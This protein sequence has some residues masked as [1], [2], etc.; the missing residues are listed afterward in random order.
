MNVDLKMNSLA[1][2]LGIEV[3]ESTKICR[4]CGR[5]LPVTAFRWRGEGTVRKRINIDC[6]EC[7]AADDR[8]RS[9]LRKTAPP[10]PL[11]CD[12]CGE[13][14]LKPYKSQHKKL[15]LDHNHKTGEFRG[16]ICD[17]CNVALSRAG[18]TTEGVKKLLLYLEA[19]Q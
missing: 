8:I 7:V 6:K 2:L 4:K 19:R 16:W 5:D 12:C 3:E 17:S 14:P 9:K 10:I 13:S 11:V 18:D 1:D 15:C